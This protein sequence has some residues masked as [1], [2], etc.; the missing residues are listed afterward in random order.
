VTGVYC[1]VDAKRRSTSRRVVWR[2]CASTCHCQDAHRGLLLACAACVF[3]VR[4][5]DPAQFREL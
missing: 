4:V 1:E 2:A 3:Y 5:A